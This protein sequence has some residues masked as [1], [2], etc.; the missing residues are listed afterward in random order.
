[1]SENKVNKDIDQIETN[2]WLD[3]LATVVE[4]EGVDRAHYLIDQLTAQIGGG[5]IR[6]SAYN[7]TIALDEQVTYPGDLAL[8][9]KITNYHRWNSIAMLLQAKEKAGDVGGH[10]STYASIATLYEVGFNHFFHA[11]SKERLGDLVYFQGHSLEGIYA[12]SFL[13]GRFDE[14]RMQNF[15]QESNQPGLS[16]YPHPWLMKDYWQ[17]ATVSLGLGGLQAV[18]QARFLKYLENRGLADTQGRKVWLFV[19]DGE[20]DEP[21]STAGGLLASREKLDNLVMVL[22]CNLIRLDGPVRSNYKVISEYERLFTGAGWRVIKVLWGPK[23]DALFAKDSKGVLL[24]ALTQC[25]DG[26]MQALIANGGAYIREHFFG[27]SPAL[28][29]LID[30]YSDDDLHALFL[31]RGGLNPQKVYAAYHQAVNNDTGQPTLI[32]AQTIKGYGVSKTAESRNVAHNTTSMSEEDLLA[33]KKRFNLDISD[34]ACKTVQLYK[35]S[36]DSPEMRYLHERR[37]ALGGYLPA[38]RIKSDERLKVPG[39]DAF[40]KYCE[41]SDDKVLSSTMAFAR[42]LNV[43]LK[44]KSIGARVVP[45]FSDEVRTFGME[46]LFRQNGIYSPV[47]QLYT[48]EDKAQ[49]MYYKEAKDGQVLEEGITEAGCMSS[50]IAAATSYSTCN[51]QMIPFFVYYSMFGFQRVGDYIWAAGDMRARGFLVGGTAGRTTLAG[52]GLQH[53]DGQSLLMASYVPNCISYDPAFSYEI[54]VIVQEGLRRMV[55]NQEDVFYYFTCMNEKYVQPAMPEGV[56]DGILKGMYLFKERDQKAKLKVQLLSSGAI[57]NEAIAAA[58]ILAKDF[59][60]EADI[61]GVPSLSELHRDGEAV[62]R[63][64]RLNPTKKPKV[65]YVETCLQGRKGPVICATDYVKAYGNLIRAFVPTDYT[66]LGTDGFGRSDDRP[67]LRQFFEVDR[68][69]IVVASLHALAK[70][71]EVP[72]ATVEAAI[73]KFGIDANKADPITC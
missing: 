7:N 32:L 27:Q 1:M 54:A 39:F 31:D 21:D 25:I 68:Y 22:N 73:K 11:D 49:L 40:A 51:L 14:A 59:Q 52:E 34:Q 57:F 43:I 41:S 17:F 42:I 71:G 70:A 12:R 26:E 63:Y 13:E 62:D 4:R 46:A 8:E 6:P 10:L 15:R 65:S 67:S 28:L 58:D 36:D 30:G 50:W 3:A 18:Y 24:D 53:Q 72:V 38:R 2:E 47:G 35:P 64:N 48:P 60:V 44:D 9:E 61:W 66:V 55:E 69:H 20:M 37:T 33:F 19:G 45:I 29:A 16:S 23:W 5:A 56:R